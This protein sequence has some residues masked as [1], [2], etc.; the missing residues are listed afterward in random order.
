[1]HMA[2]IASGTISVLRLMFRDGPGTEQLIAGDESRATCR[3]RDLR[4]GMIS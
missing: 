1:M 4:K 2:A 3:W